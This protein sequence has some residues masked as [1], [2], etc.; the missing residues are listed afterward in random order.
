MSG[1]ASLGLSSSNIPALNGAPPAP[2]A[3]GLSALGLSSGAIPSLNGA[4][5]AP[6]GGGLGAVANNVALASAAPKPDYQ[7][8]FRKNHGTAFD[9]KSS[10]DRRKMQQMQSGMA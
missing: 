7:A 4:G 9:P 10:M 1:L 6:T 2:P 3:G 5:P 8:M